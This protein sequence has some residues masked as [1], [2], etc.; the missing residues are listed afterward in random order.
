MSDQQTEGKTPSDSGDAQDFEQQADTPQ[1]SLLGEFWEFLRYNKKWWLTPIILVLLLVGT[2][3][4]LSGTAVA[5]F[6]YTLW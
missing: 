6:L 2:L 1:I 3:V 5:P 4:V